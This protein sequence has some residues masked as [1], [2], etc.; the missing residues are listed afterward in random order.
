M[1]LRYVIE[2][3]VK[4]ALGSDAVLVTNLKKAYDHYYLIYCKEREVTPLSY[5]TAAGDL[6]SKGHFWHG[7]AEVYITKRMVF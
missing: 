3:K 2:V 6:K 5:S 7:D 4:R 1:I